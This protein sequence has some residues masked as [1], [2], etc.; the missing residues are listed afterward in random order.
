MKKEDVTVYATHTCSF[1]HALINWLKVNEIEHEA[2]MIDTDL[3]AQK[4][5]LDKI[6][7]NFQ[8]VPVSFVNEEM[9][10]GFDRN[11]LKDIFTQAGYSIKEDF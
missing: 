1:C 11:R 2:K 4:E 6:G 8:G 10:L 3:N 9:V 5:L 7:G